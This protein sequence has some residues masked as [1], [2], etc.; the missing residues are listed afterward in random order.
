[1]ALVDITH[2]SYIE[3]ARELLKENINADL[4][5]LCVEMNNA[6]REENKKL[7]SNFVNTLVVC[8]LY[9]YNYEAAKLGMTKCI[10]VEPYV[11]LTVNEAN[12]TLAIL[13]RSL[14]LLLK[15]DFSVVM[16]EI[17]RYLEVE[18]E[19]GDDALPFN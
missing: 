15:D 16:N 17:E 19:M 5:P 14:S 2:N 1:M 3:K 13:W 8:G 6:K 4:K 10:V 7:M 12:K 9:D 11:K 18:R